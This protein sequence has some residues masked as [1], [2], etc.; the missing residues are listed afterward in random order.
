ML[1]VDDVVLVDD[2]SR[3][4]DLRVTET[5]ITSA[6][7]DKEYSRGV[8]VETYSHFKYKLGTIV[9]LFSHNVYRHRIGSFAVVEVPVTIKK[10]YDAFHPNW[11]KFVKANAG[12][13]V[14][15]KGLH[16]MFH[17]PDGSYS[18]E[19]FRGWNVESYQKIEGVRPGPDCASWLP[20]EWLIPVVN[21]ALS[22]D[23]STQ[24][25]MIEGCQIP[26]HQ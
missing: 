3:V 8:V 12:K 11:L 24:D 7:S 5:G 15:L 14:Q 18:E 6:Y 21:R 22:C 17:G 13:V 26:W 16:D 23:C 4:Y 20:K 1:K 2:W 19:S 10:P 9:T 25:L